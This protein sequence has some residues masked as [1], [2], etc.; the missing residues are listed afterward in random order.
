MPAEKSC[1][2]QCGML[3]QS[4]TNRRSCHIEA[5]CGTELH[6]AQATRLLANNSMNACQHDLL[7]GRK[8][9]DAAHLG[10]DG[11]SHSKQGQSQIGKSVPICFNLFCLCHFEELQAHQTCTCLTCIGECIQEI[12]IEQTESGQEPATHCKWPLMYLMKTALC[13]DSMTT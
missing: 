6:V 8:A 10:G 9:E 4:G 2:K 3:L 7:E 5:W 11:L 12:A 13:V 1:N